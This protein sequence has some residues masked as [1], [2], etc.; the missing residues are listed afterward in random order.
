MATESLPELTDKQRK[1]LK[2]VAFT[3]RPSSLLDIGMSRSGVS[4]QALD[5]RGRPRYGEWHLELRPGAVILS[6]IIDER[7][8]AWRMSHR[9]LDL[10]WR[11]VVQSLLDWQK[12]V[13][14]V[15]LRTL[16]R[17]DPRL[18]HLDPSTVSDPDDYSLQGRPTW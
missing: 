14:G 9:E 4:I 1:D 8:R 2:S 16:I 6:A 11:L 18:A 15:E 17:E 5:E 10:N 7:E 13:N 12:A 3:A